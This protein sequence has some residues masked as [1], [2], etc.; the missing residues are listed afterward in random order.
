MLYLID[1]SSLI[2]VFYSF[3]SPNMVP[4]YWSWLEF[5][6]RKGVCQLFPLSRNLL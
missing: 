5:Q 4:E 6:A 1:A 3:Y 2:T